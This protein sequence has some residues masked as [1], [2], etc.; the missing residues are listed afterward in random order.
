MSVQILQ[1]DV[2]AMLAT[3]PAESVQC[4]VTVAG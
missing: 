3:L 4:V 2:R 1:G